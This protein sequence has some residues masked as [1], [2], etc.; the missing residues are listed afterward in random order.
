MIIKQ[1][2]PKNLRNSVIEWTYPFFNTHMDEIA[3][4]EY[5]KEVTNWELS[6]LLMDGDIIKGVYL[7]GD[8]TIEWFVTHSEWNEKYSKLKGVEGVLLV[9]DSSIRNQGWG[10]KLKDYP[11]SLG[12]DYIWGQQFKSLNNLDD[13][14]KRRELITITDDCYI[15]LELF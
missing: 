1:G 6:I 10:N 7:F 14:L 3:F 8:S 13:W 12:V 15:T 5:L 9:V 4:L 11:K 2:I